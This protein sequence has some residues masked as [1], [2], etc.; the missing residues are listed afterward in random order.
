ALVEVAAVVEVVNRAVGGDRHGL[1][2][3]GDGREGQ[4]AIDRVDAQRAVALENDNVAA[5][6]HLEGG[7]ANV[8]PRPAGA[9][10]PPQLAVVLQIHQ[11][12]PRQGDGIHAGVERNAAAGGDLR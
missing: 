2:V 9:R 4:R 10:V 12:G 5:A 6:V 7:D 11:A 1:H 8:Q 3:G